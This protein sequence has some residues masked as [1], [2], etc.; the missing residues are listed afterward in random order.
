MNTETNYWKV[1]ISYLQKSQLLVAAKSADEALEMV[2]ANVADGT[3]QFA[4][5][6]VVEL[7]DEE[8]EWVLKNMQG[9]NAET[10]EPS[11]EVA[12]VRTLN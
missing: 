7:T 8:K 2:K 3:E 5:G 12:D 10:D 6:A 9:L 1:D 4:V 11:G